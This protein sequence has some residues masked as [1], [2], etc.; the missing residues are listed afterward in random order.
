MLN[1]DLPRSAMVLTGWLH[2]TRG[3]L[4]TDENA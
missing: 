4:H 3:R 2:I 1:E